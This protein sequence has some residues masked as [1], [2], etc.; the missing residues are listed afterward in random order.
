[1]QQANKQTP[2]SMRRL[3]YCWTITRCY[4]QDSLKQWV[5]CQQFSWVKWH[6]VTGWWVREFICQFSWK[7]THEEKTRRLVWNGHQL[8]TQLVEDW[9]LRRVLHGWL[10]QEDLWAESQRISLGRSRCQETASGDCNRLRTLV[11][12]CQ[13]AVIVYFQVLYTRDQ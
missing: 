7:P 8:G 11:C 5:S 9:Q 10:W 1:M 4:K 13:W 2:V 6:E 3:R 12:M